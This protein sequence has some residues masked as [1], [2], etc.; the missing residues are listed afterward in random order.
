MKS[1]AV[2]SYM[3]GTN[4]VISPTNVKIFDPHGET[5]GSGQNEASTLQA[6]MCAFIIALCFTATCIYSVPTIRTIRTVIITIFLFI[7][8]HI[9]FLLQ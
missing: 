1:I 2:P 9:K 4:T 5:A 3:R 8:S 7:Q 6:I